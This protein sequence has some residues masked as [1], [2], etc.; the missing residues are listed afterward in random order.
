MIKDSDVHTSL[1]YIGENL[2][3]LRKLELGLT[4][5]E[6]AELVGMSKDAVSKIERGVVMPSLKSMMDI[7]KATNKPIDYFLKKRSGR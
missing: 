5:E 4:Q 1:S 7:S 3:L 2:Y 6:F